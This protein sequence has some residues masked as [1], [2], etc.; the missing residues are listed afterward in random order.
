MKDM[1]AIGDAAL[2]TLPSEGRPVILLASDCLNV[3]CGGVFEYLAETSRFDVPISVLRLSSVT[4]VSDT[5]TTSNYSPFPL[6]VSDDAKSVRDASQLSGGIFLDVSALDSYTNMTAG[7]P[8]GTSSP[9]YGDIHFTSKKR[10]I[11]PNA[12]QW[13]SLFTMSPLTPG[14]TSQ[15]P[16]RPINLHNNLSIQHGST[17]FSSSG[18]VSTKH[19][20]IQDSLSTFTGITTLLSNQSF[21]ITKLGPTSNVEV[22]FSS[23]AAALNERTMFSKYNINP[24]RIKSLLMTRILEGYRAR[25]YG[26]NTQDPGASQCFD[27]IA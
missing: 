26:Q 3:N 7:S 21:D 9:F 20:Q 24:V 11:R 18:S 23:Q 2:A 4:S 1:L 22:S 27:V 16:P 12:L 10:S 14:Y 19:H 13:Y 6:G 17:I 8:V 15:S 5:S 25:R